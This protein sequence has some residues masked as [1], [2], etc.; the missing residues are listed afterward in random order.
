MIQQEFDFT[1][2]MTKN[3]APVVIILLI[4][5]LG[6]GYLFRFVFIRRSEDR[7]ALLRDWKAIKPLSKKLTNR[8][9]LK[10]YPFADRSFEIKG[11]IYTIDSKTKT[12]EYSISEVNEKHIEEIDKKINTI[13]SRI[14][15]LKEG[16]TIKDSD[17]QKV[18]QSLKNQKKEQVIS[19]DIKI[20]KFDQEIK[21]IEEKLAQNV[22]WTNKKST[23]QKLQDS[24]EKL[25]LEKGKL[26]AIQPLKM[27]LELQ[28]SKKSLEEEKLKF[29]ALEE[30][31][32]KKEDQKITIKEKTETYAALDKSSNTLVGFRYTNLK[33]TQSVLSE[34]GFLALS[35]IDP[36]RNTTVL[37]LIMAVLVAF[38]FINVYAMLEQVEV[39]FLFAPNMWGWYVALAIIIG[40]VFYIM[41]VLFGFYAIVYAEVVTYEEIRLSSSDGKNF[42]KTIPIYWLQTYFYPNIQVENV[43][44]IETDSLAFKINQKL[45]Q[46]VTDFST[47]VANLQGELDF[48]Y[49]LLDDKSKTVDTMEERLLLERSIGYYEGRKDNSATPEANAYNQSTVDWTLITYRAIPFIFGL[50]TLGGLIIGIKWIADTIDLDPMQTTIIFI[51]GVVILLIGLIVAFR[52]LMESTRRSAIG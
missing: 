28:D 30:F 26:T 42:T 3:F 25:K 22:D 31:I 51:A 24:L 4:V 37:Y 9:T 36:R 6:V 45:R 41:K 11:D 47:K 50:I 8:L 17:L 15:K 27:I 48:A 29:Q 39:D 38:N 2:F 33:P 5:I 35:F 19:V 18:I 43:L 20:M 14:L 52:S 16:I 12:T 23:F 10:V 34:T 32:P 1:E 7:R 21:T 40:F 13:Q 44:G 46:K 49:S